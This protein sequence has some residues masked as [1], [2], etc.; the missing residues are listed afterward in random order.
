MYLNDLEVFY[1]RVFNVTS[2]ALDPTAPAAS[3]PPWTPNW[4]P[5]QLRSIIDKAVRIARGSVVR[6]TARGCVATVGDFVRAGGAGMMVELI[7]VDGNRY[8][9]DYIHI[10]PISS[11]EALGECAD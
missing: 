11:L 7:D 10:D 3:T 8:C 4:D 9:Q 2:V 6:D 5:K 1:D